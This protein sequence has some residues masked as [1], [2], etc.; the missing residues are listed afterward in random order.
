MNEKA[1]DH[2]GKDQRDAATSQGMPTASRSWKR[3]EQSLP[4]SLCILYFLLPEP[5]ENNFCRRLCGNLLNWNQEAK[6]VT[7]SRPLAG[8]GV[9]RKQSP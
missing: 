8:E 1:Y 2:R 7:Y 4:L 9:L 6:I 5:W 3:Q